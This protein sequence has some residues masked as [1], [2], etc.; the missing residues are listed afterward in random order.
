VS[1]REDIYEALF[2]KFLALKNAPFAVVSRKLRPLEDL[3]AAEF[4]ALFLTLGKQQFAEKSGLPAKRTY[5]AS[6][7]IFVASPN[8][9]IPSGIQLNNLLDVAEAALITGNMFQPQQTLGGLVEHAWFAGTVDVYEAV[10]AQRAA[11][12]ASISMLI[13]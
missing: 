1:G 8:D 2:A 9:A 5:N 3:S 7:I 10:K 12:I 4:P 13:P 6:L 11:A